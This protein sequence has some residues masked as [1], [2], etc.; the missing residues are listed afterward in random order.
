[1][2]EAPNFKEIAGAFLFPNACLFTFFIQGSL[3]QGVK[4]CNAFH[5]F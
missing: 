5:D 3:V 2:F 1:M 4:L